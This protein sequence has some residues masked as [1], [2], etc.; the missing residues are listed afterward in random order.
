M[1]RKRVSGHAEEA[2]R[3]V[4]MPMLLRRARRTYAAAMREEL[5]ARGLEDLPRNGPFVIRA[6]Q[7]ASTP[8]SEIARDLSV[9]KQAASKLID[10]LVVRGFLERTV[11][12]IDRR[13]ISLALTERGRQAA[14]AVDAG[15]N[16][17]D[18]DLATALTAS[19]LAGFRAGLQA[20]LEMEGRYGPPDD[21]FELASATLNGHSRRRQD[22]GRRR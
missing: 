21:D 17:V 9:S 15:T 8:L 2:D 18:A 12:P 3:D 19:Q 14:A 6:M 20:L 4:T 7:H 22:P 11:D 1:A 10:L 16:R 5:R 13:R